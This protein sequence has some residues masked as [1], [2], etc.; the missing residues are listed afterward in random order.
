MIGGAFWPH[1]EKVITVVCQATS[2]GSSP[3]VV[4]HNLGASVEIAQHER[5]GNLA[6]CAIRPVA[7]KRAPFGAGQRYKSVTLTT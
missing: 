6:G 3:H 5:L 7:R 1:S 4:A 2:W